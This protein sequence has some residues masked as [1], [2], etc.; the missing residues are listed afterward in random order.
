MQPRLPD[1][2]AAIPVEGLSLD[3]LSALAS[4]ILDARG[5]MVTDGRAS[6]RVDPRTV[7]FYQTLGI[8]PKPAYI[9]RRAMYGR[10][11][12]VRVVV[13]KEL[14]AE[15]HSLSQIHEGLAMHATD[16]LVAA[17]L[18]SDASRAPRTAPAVEPRRV[19]EQSSS[20]SSPQSSARPATV[21][22]PAAAMPLRSFQIAP[23]VTV[24]IDPALVESPTQLADALAKAL[25]SS[26]GH[27]ADP[28]TADPVTTD[29]VTTDAHSRKPRGGKD[30]SV[31]AEE[32]RTQVSPNRSQSRR[33][34]RQPRPHGGNR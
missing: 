32:S 33:S 11:H 34:T 29:P 15:G 17:L 14:Q 26:V 21:A 30:A 24:L 16:D 5:V 31:A 27:A 12:L 20:Q 4:R 1:L 25:A 8:V 9:G 13:A 7:R 10:E 23:G 18:K 22:A 6:D 2:L 19:A 28:V 3:E